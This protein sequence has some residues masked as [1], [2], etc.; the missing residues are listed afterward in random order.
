MLC[1]RLQYSKAQN[2]KNPIDFIHCYNYLNLLFKLLLPA[3]R[4][5][6]DVLGGYWAPCSTITEWKILS[7]HHIAHKA[8]IDTTR[9]WWY[10]YT[11]KGKLCPLMGRWHISHVLS[12]E[13]HG[14]LSALQ[15]WTLAQGCMG[16]SEHWDQ[17][18]LVQLC[19]ISLETVQR[20]IS[21][22]CSPK[23]W[24][25]KFKFPMVL[26]AIFSAVFWL[27]AICSLPSLHFLSS[28]LYAK[29]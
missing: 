29:V 12:L 3:H 14:A 26:L 6:S 17:H 20:F 1:H 13:N 19:N 2:N 9:C 4:V 10:A 18:P 11:R 5:P 7:Q 22:P 15:S 25:S 8:A 27:Q 23:L 16:R 28:L 21:L 24:S